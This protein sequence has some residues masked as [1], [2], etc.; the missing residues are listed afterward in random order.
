MHHIHVQLFPRQLRGIA[1]G[2]HQNALTV[3]DQIV[4]VD[5]HISGEATVG[6]VVLGQMRVGVGIAKII[7]GDNFE[8]IRASA[9]ENGAQY[10]PA[11]ASVTV[12]CNSYRHIVSSS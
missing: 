1:F 4:T 12:D 11:N 7:D 6:G 10:V 2:T 3:D 5:A 9:L 8:F